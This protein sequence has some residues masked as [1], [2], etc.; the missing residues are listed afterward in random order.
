MKIRFPQMKRA[1]W[2]DRFVEISRAVD[3]GTAPRSL[4]VAAGLRARARAASNGLR[5]VRPVA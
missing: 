2:R 5:H 4:V 3:A 1:S